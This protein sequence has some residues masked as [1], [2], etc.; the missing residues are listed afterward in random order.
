MRAA[1]HTR[2]VTLDGVAPNSLGLMGN[3]ASDFD[4]AIERQLAACSS[5]AACAELG[6]SRG[7]LTTLLAQLE[8]APLPVR[9]R[10]AV[11]GELTTGTLRR[12]TLAELVSRWAYHP[13]WHSLLPLLL[14]EASEGRVEA[15]AALAKSGQST[16]EENVMYR[17]VLCTEDEAEITE[18]PPPPSSLLGNSVVK[19]LKTECSKWPRGDRPADFREPL[20][21]HVPVLLM[22][23][24][25]DPVT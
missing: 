5:D 8:A 20:T 15:L 18:K 7:H 24:E 6:D 12:S 11:T 4:D 22:S 2:T 25:L 9:Y 21:G 13:E 1:E 23:G 10:D 17:S 14:K 3:F 19:A 16:A